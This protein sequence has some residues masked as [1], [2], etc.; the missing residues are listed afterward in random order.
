MQVEKIDQLQ[1]Q[2]RQLMHTNAK[3]QEQAAA[4]P[5]VDTSII[6]D[7]KGSTHGSPAKQTK[8][9]EMLRGETKQQ[10]AAKRRVLHH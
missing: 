10:R 1:A 7:V 6:T 9:G 2:I 5:E 3:L 8:A 4:K